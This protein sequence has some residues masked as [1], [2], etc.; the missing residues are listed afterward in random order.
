MANGYNELSFNG[1]TMTLFAVPTYPFGFKIAQ[2]DPGEDPLDIPNVDQA[3]VSMG[4]NGNVIAYRNPYT[5]TLT[6]PLV[7]GSDEDICMMNIA[8]ADRIRWGKASV[9]N[10]IQLLVNYPD[11]KIRTLINGTLTN[12]PIA[13]GGATDGRIKLHSFTVVFGSIV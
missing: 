12:A 3:T 1:T 8:E 11:G 13:Y 7:P 10:N 9:K 6:F 4:V 2:F 5:I